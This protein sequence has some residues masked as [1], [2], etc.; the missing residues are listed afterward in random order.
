MASADANHL[1]FAC[2]GN[3]ATIMERREVAHSDDGGRTWMVTLN[4]VV[5]GHLSD[6]APKTMRKVDVS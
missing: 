4:E 6:L 5:T 3:G 2:A 1:W